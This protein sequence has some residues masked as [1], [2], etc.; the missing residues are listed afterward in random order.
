M[1]GLRTTS[2][3]V[4]DDCDADALKISKALAQRGIGAILVP[5]ASDERRPGCPLSGIRV[6]VLDIN[7]GNE[8]ST[9][10]LGRIRHTAGVVNGLI[11]RTNG[12]YVAVVWTAN[13]EEYTEFQKALQSIGCPPVLTVKLD[14][15]EVLPLKPD[16]AADEILGTI[17]KAVTKAPPLEFANFWEQIVRDAGNDTIV[18]LALRRVPQQQ[19]P[20]ALDFLAAL[21]K[22]EANDSALRENL[23]SMKALLAA[24]N[25]VHFDKVEERSTRIEPGDTIV[26]DPIRKA[27]VEEDRKLTIFQKSQL[28]SSLLFDSRVKGFGPG[29]LY[30]FDDIKALRIGT[31]LPNKE[32]IL[33]DTVEEA[34]IERADKLSVVFLEVSAPCDHQQD[35]VRTARLLA[36]VVFAAKTFR[37]GSKKKRVNARSADFL[38]VL[39]SVRIAEIGDF[40]SE[41]VSIAWNAHFPVSVQKERIAKKNPIGRFREP[42]LTDVRAWLGYQSGRPGYTSVG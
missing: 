32:E 21:L 35:K 30:L 36:G 10:M 17:E 34:H 37:R 27:A 15:P 33:K 13:K 20:E 24:L 25:Q 18:S 23:Q 3:L 40:P 11:D 26:V 41:E 28:N 38:R 29:H 42:L 6:A 39:D 2:V 12:P 1:H 9:T 16:E 31:A 19:E 4:L 5:G 14:K 22:S 7:L 8:T